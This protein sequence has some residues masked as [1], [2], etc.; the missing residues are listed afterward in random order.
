MSTRERW[1]VYPLLFLTLG[2]VM[3]DKFVPAAHFQAEEVTARQI[4]CSQ[5]QADQT[6]HCGQLQADQI[7][8][9]QLRL[10]T[11]NLKWAVPPIEKPKTPPTPAPKQPSKEP[12]KAPAKASK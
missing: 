3:R 8:W 11:P 1:I 7:L 2:M 12:E 4:H 10:D 5:L 9:R 6:V